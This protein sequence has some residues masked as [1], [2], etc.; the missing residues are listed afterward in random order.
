MDQVL[1]SKTKLFVNKTNFVLY[2]SWIGGVWGS[3]TLIIAIHRYDVVVVSCLLNN[4][5][6]HDNIEQI[7][8]ERV[9][10]IYHAKQ[11]S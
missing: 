8:L 2:Y 11:S 5:L 1:F 10:N 4:K 3:E 6:L 7:K 9:I